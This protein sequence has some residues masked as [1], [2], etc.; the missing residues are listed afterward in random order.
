M[1]TNPFAEVWDSLREIID[2]PN[3][4][5]RKQMLFAWFDRWVGQLY[6]ESVIDVEVMLNMADP[7]YIREFHRRDISHKI[8]AELVKKIDEYGTK[9]VFTTD[10]ML[11]HYMPGSEVTRYSFSLLR[12]KD[13]VPK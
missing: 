11:A 6:I 12:N 10:S 1:L 7:E 5:R 3:Q 13:K 8:A 9:T 4:S 2:E